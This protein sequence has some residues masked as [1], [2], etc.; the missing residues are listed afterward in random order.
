MAQKFSRYTKGGKVDSTGFWTRSIFIKS[1]DDISITISKKYHRRPH[2]LA[3]DIY[4]SSELSWFI[5]QYNNIIDVHT[6]FVEGVELTLPTATRFTAG[7][8]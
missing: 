7:M 5:L 3:S 1:Y 6:E 2:L 4:G 8:V